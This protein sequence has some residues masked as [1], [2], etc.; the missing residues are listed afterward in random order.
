MLTHIERSV[1]CLKGLSVGD[2][3]GKQTETLK[4]DAVKQ[5]YPAG[6]S[7]FHGEVGSVI[8]RYVGKRYEWRVGETTDDTEQTLAVADALI[9]EGALSHS[10]VGQRLMNSRSFRS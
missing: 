6:I 2:A 4:R 5:W 8:P 9:T 3:V 1:A 7:G 10:S